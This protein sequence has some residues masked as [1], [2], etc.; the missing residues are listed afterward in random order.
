MAAFL[1]LAAL[2]HGL[3]STVLRARYEGDLKRGI[4]R[5][6][7]VEYTLSATI[8]ILLIAF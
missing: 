5:F 4:N 7:W 1:A 3:S 2:D 8:M 6:R